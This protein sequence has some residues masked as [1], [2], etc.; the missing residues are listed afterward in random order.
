ML[1]RLKHVYII[2]TLNEYF[3]DRINSEIQI[4]VCIRLVRL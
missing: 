1:K 4:G 2:Q 3:T